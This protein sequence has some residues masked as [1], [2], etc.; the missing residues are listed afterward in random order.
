MQE[1]PQDGS[2]FLGDCDGAACRKTGVL[3]RRLKLDR[4]E[5]GAQVYLCA[6]DWRL[7]MKNR[8]WLNKS[9]VLNPWDVYGFY[10][11][12]PDHEQSEPSMIEMQNVVYPIINYTPN[13]SLK[14][15]VFATFKNMNDVLVT[16]RYAHNVPVEELKDT[17]ISTGEHM[18][19]TQRLYG[20]ISVFRAT[21][22]QQQL[23]YNREL[24]DYVYEAIVV[25]GKEVL[26]Y[27]P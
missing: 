15:D 14:R 4:V 19:T 25:N 12:E 21:T 13:M 8:D 6:T 3:V 2:Y 18:R 11:P 17:L 5:E 24:S 1:L 23:T 26:K 9:G 22:D 7:E 20:L 27:E 16:V 10:N